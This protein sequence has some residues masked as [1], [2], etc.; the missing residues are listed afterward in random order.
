VPLPL[1]E[2][3]ILPEIENVAVAVKFTL[4]TLALV[5]LTAWLAGLNANP[6]FVGVT[7]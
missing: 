1:V 3:V 5:M 6:L 4:V 2:G 7:V